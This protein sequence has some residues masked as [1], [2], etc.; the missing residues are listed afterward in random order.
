MNIHYEIRANFSYNPH[1][2]H[3]PAREPALMRLTNLICHGYEGMT[4]V[5]YKSDPYTGDVVKIIF[6]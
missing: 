1:M 4:P 2:V 5:V 3:M 6:S